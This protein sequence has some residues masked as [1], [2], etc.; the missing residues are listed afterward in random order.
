MNLKGF[1]LYSISDFIDKGYEF[2]HIDEMNNTTV[3][4]KM[5]M[6]YNYYIQNP[7]SMVELRLHMVIAENPHLIKSL[8]RSHIHP[9]IRK[10]SYIR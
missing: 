5:Y 3:N 2:S 6:S 8:N 9:L 4:D 1:L 10:Y 7:M